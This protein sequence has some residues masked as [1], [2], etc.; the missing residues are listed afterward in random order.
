MA[1]KKKNNNPSIR[2]WLYACEADEISGKFTM[3][4]PELYEAE[5]VQ[6]LSPQA[7]DFYVFLNVYRSTEQ[8]QACLYR[9]LTEYNKVQGLGMSDLDIQNEAILSKNCK[10]N[11]GLFVAPKSYIEK[12]GYTDSKAK[13]YKRE[14][15]AKG[16]IKRKYYGLGYIQGYENNITVYQFTNDW[17]G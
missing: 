11:Q 1:K 2:K 16:F 15:I 10:C 17:K 12:Y 7:R 14:L 9:I 3:I 4:P 13:R 6:A 8:Q 5:K